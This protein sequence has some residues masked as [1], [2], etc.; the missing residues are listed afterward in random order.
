M[1]IAPDNLQ[2]SK[3]LLNAILDNMESA[4]LLLDADMRIH[5]VNRRF[6]ELFRHSG[7]S[8]V[9]I[10]CGNALSCGH[11]VEE[12]VTCGKSSRCAECGLRGAAK[13]ALTGEIPKRSKLV[14]RFYLRGAPERKHLD[15]CCRPM[16]Y[17]RLSKA[18]MSLGRCWSK[19]CPQKNT[20]T[21]T[22]SSDNSTG[23]RT[24]TPTSKTPTTS[25]PSWTKPAV[26]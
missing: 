6:Q 12:N 3:E 23:T 24:S 19:I 1:P 26:V 9:G 11:A 17:R 13:Q 18:A 8:V 16:N 2:E 20:K 4:V 25:S 10:C 15:F 22:S 7:E 21:S 14:R 5:H